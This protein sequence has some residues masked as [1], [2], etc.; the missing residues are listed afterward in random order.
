MTDDGLFEVYTGVGDI[1]KTTEIIK[2]N[3][4][5]ANSFWTNEKDG[6]TSVCNMI[7]GTDTASFPPH[8]KPQGYLNIYSTDICR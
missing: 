3:D 5:E 2:L 6:K 1:N 7:N 4:K 8:L